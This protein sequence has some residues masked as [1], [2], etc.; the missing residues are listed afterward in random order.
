MRRV[1]ENA[2]FRAGAMVA[3]PVVSEITGK[4]GVSQKRIFFD[5]KCMD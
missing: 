4:S 5:R 2:V 1:V 3:L